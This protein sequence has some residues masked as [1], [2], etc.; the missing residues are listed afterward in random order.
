MGVMYVTGETPHNFNPFT[1]I[2]YKGRLI[3]LRRGFFKNSSSCGG[4]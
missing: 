1:C 4:D 3:T 2:Y